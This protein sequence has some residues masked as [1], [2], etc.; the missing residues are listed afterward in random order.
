MVSVK[1]CTPKITILTNLIFG[2]QLQ[3][4]QKIIHH[5]YVNYNYHPKTGHYNNYYSYEDHYSEDFPDVIY[6]YEYIL[7][8]VHGEKNLAPAKRFNKRFGLFSGAP[9]TSTINGKFDRRQIEP[10]R[11]QF[12][13]IN[14]AQL[15]FFSFGMIYGKDQTQTTNTKHCR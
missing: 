2:K 14:P 3:V 12:T 11:R 9:T 1:S 6:E 13:A 5:H 7:E 15:L 10:I 8:E 4:H